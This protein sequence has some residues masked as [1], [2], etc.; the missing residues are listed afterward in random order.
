MTISKDNKEFLDGKG[1]LDD[2]SFFSKS[3]YQDSSTGVPDSKDLSRTKG[4]WP[5]AEDPAEAA[6][7]KI[8]NTITKKGT[9]VRKLRR[10]ISTLIVNR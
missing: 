6:A 10:Y 2:N 4:S 5:K 1:V 9:N 8:G 7:A 3:V